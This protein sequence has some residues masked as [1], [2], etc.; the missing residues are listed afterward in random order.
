M[1]KRLVVNN[2]AK[3]STVT[4]TCK[5]KACPKRLVKRNA[6]GTVDLGSYAREAFRAGA[7]ITVKVSKAGTNT[8]V[9]RLTIRKAK[10]P[11]VTYG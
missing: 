5:G 3:G 1:L 10:K 9:M 7:V 4:V 11:T 6:S 2:V 8:T